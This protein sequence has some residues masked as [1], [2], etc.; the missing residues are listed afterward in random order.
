MRTLGEYGYLVAFVLFF[1]TAL[2]MRND[3]FGRGPAPRTL[4]GLTP[5]VPLY[6]TWFLVARTRV[7]TDVGVLIPYSNGI[8][9]LRSQGWAFPLAFPSGLFAVVLITNLVVA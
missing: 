2:A 6:R 9:R 7:A 8:D 1:L 4:G 5:G 3:P